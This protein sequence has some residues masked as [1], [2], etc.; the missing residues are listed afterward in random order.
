MQL[1][2]DSDQAESQQEQPQPLDVDGLQ[3]AR[4]SRVDNIVKLGDTVMHVKNV[5]SKIQWEPSNNLLGKFV[6]RVL[7]RSYVL[8]MSLIASF[9]CLLLGESTFAKP[10]GHQLLVK[11]VLGALSLKQ[12]GTFIW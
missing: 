9:W 10:D 5:A 8:I 1:P 7:P 4:S 3:L 2:E 12:D 11:E 6:Q